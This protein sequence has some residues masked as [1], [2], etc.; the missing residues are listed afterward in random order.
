ML[1]DDERLWAPDCYEIRPMSPLSSPEC[2]FQ[3][4]QPIA[5]AITLAGDGAMPAVAE[6]LAVSDV[7]SEEDRNPAAVRRRNHE[8]PSSA[9]DCDDPQRAARDRKNCGSG[10]GSDGDKRTG[11]TENERLARPLEETRQARQFKPADAESVTCVDRTE[12]VTYVDRSGVHSKQ[13]GDAAEK[14]RRPSQQPAV[15]RLSSQ[16]RRYNVAIRIN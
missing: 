14:E 2:D 10:D 11:G 16:V 4:K 3:S 8:E 5:A 15:H 1:P 7:E 9:T 13:E 12:S 6:L